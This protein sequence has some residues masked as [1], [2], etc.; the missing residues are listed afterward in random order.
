M[1]LIPILFFFSGFTA[2]IYQMVWMRELVLVF[3]ASMFAISTLLTAFMGG[4]ALGSWYFGKRADRYSN[5]LFVYALL[6]LGI[7]GYAFL[8]PL[9][10]SS[11]IPVYQSLS[12]L[13]DFSF[14]AFSLVR[15]FL[16][17]LILLLPTAFMGGT[18]PVLAQLYKNRE[19]VGKG[20]GLLYAFNTFGAVMGVLGAG[21]ILLPALGL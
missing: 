11:L 8:V 15:F 6:E 1:F 19:T 13:F 5:P 4:L 7:G 9:F 18:L 2:L 14:Y 21:F 17:V 16:A 12:D 3:G 10:F 20:V